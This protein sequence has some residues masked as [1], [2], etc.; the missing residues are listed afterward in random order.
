MSVLTL[1]TAVEQ[2][3]TPA[4][5][6]HRLRTSR[7]WR[8]MTPEQLGEAVDRNARSIRRYEAGTITPPL[9]IACAMSV[10]LG[11]PLVDLFE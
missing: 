11:V 4:F 9:N 3:Q 8:K 1:G 5:S 10:A 6:G 7:I 2:T